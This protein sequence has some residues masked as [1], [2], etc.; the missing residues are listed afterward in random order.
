MLGPKLNAT[1]PREK[2]E[3]TMKGES[4]KGGEQGGELTRGKKK[5][6]S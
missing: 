6:I 4:L 1:D 2:G 3:F 5:V